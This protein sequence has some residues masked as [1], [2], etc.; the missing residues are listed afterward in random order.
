MQIKFF[1]KEKSFK[2]EDLKVNLNLYWQCAVGG[3]AVIILLS[4]LF[5]YSTF[6]GLN[7][8]TNTYAG[9]SDS[10]PTVSNDRIEKDL[11]YFSDRAQESTDI[12]NSPSPV[13]DPSL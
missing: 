1:K 11:N 10:V 12:I 7:D 2:K 5:G 9:V 4:F 8:D 13:A 3:A 6:T